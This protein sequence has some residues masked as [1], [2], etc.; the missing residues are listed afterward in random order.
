MDLDDS[1]MLPSQDDDSFLLSTRPISSPLRQ[2]Q[3]PERNPIERESRRV[4]GGRKLEDGRRRT[5]EIVAR[6]R[7]ERKK[8]ESRDRAVSSSTSVQ[9]VQPLSTQKVSKEDHADDQEK[10]AWEDIQDPGKENG[11]LPDSIPNFLAKLTGSVF[12]LGCMSKDY[13]RQRTRSTQS[14]PSSREEYVAKLKARL[15]ESRMRRENSFVKMDKGDEVSSSGFV[16]GDLSLEPKLTATLF[17]VFLFRIRLDLEQSWT[18]HRRS[19]TALSQG[20]CLGEI[21]PHGP[22]LR[23]T[24]PSRDL[25][26]PRYRRA[27]ITVKRTLPA[28]LYLSIK[29]TGGVRETGW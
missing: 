11:E 28:R 7:E 17:V 25:P 27:H 1:V 16:I 14:S 22:G 9:G 24:H 10:G 23:G 2:T 18:N 15:A 6:L 5:E 29:K 3:I 21:D 19:V 20:S 8:R 26:L 13:T 4:A 12:M